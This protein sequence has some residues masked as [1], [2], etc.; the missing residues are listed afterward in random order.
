MSVVRS[1][2]VLYKE[3]VPSVILTVV[4]LGASISES[5]GS[6]SSV[7]AV[8]PQKSQEKDFTL[9]GIISLV[10]LE[11]SRKAE[12]SILVTLSGIVKLVFVWGTRYKVAFSLL[13]NAPSW[14]A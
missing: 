5:P 10:R 2:N 4:K 13:N 1:E 8:Q 6:V 3:S 7:S 12:F 14:L 11:H 9:S